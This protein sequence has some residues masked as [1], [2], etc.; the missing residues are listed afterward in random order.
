M[1]KKKLSEIEKDF[2]WELATNNIQNS[3]KVFK[4]IDDMDGL[5]AYCNKHNIEE[6]FH[7]FLE[8]NNE[9]LENNDTFF[10]FS[11]LVKKKKIQTL[12][13][14]R[15]GLK[16]CEEFGKNK[17]NYVTLKGLS[18]IDIIDVDSRL[19]RDL[20]I[21]VDIED[22]Q[23]SV[24]IAQKNGF[25][26]KNNK[27]FTKELITKNLD[28]YCLP[29][30]YNKDNVVLE[31]HY[32]II[33]NEYTQCKLSSDILTKKKLISAYGHQFFVPPNEYKF[34]HLAYHSISKG[35]FDVG[36]SS[37]FD[38]FLF[39]RNG[40][41]NSDKIN[42]LAQIYNLSRDIDILNLVLL[43]SENKL[44]NLNGQKYLTIVKSLF[45]Q[46]VVNKR[47]TGYHLASGLLG[48][49]SYLIKYL[50][51][52]KEILK[53]DFN[54]NNSIILYLLTPLRWLRQITLK[55]FSFKDFLLNY[56]DERRRA[57]N[58][59]S[60]KRASLNKQSYK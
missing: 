55:G 42:Q 20:D 2:F 50:F 49:L 56:N 5:F 28:K 18:Y 6:H 8:K 10:R 15:S 40:M 26:F 23:K 46:P 24:E 32:R 31:I 51:V 43:E 35:N 17:V 45:L 34:I 37:I 38:L 1:N 41:I 14:I 22:I 7:R 33:S 36:V 11:D 52:G 27:I 59:L 47:I 13:N 39:K 16:L 29:Q 30:M 60:L 21:L 3:I 57:R 4:K 25:K 48:K 53:R 9:N 12:M 54:F 44:N 19:F 58:I